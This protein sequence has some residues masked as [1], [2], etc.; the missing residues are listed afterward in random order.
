M[1]LNKGDII[2][3]ESNNYIIIEI[4][5]YNYEKY[6]FVNELE[7]DENI[8]KDYYILKINN[9]EANKVTNEKLINIL[10]EK[11]KILI[12]ED[13]DNIIKINES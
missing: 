4:L 8:G 6:A 3:V 11:F 2:N 9:N 5:N 1:E 13:I 12:N 10:L 7:N